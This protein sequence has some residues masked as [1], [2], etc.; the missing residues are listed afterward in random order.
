MLHFFKWSEGQRSISALSPLMFTHAAVQV[1]TVA[2]RAVCVSE[3]TPRHRHPPI[4]KLYLTCMRAWS[5]VCMLACT[6]VSHRA[7]D[8]MQIPCTVC[9]RGLRTQNNIRAVAAKHA[10]QRCVRGLSCS[11]EFTLHFTYVRSFE[12]TQVKRTGLH[13]WLRHRKAKMCPF[14]RHRKHIC[15]HR[16]L[17]SCARSIIFFFCL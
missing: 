11:A 2:H 3:T 13:K 16:F 1:L 8:S 12:D 14:N 17:S 6:R 10:Q 5:W 15:R 4:F 7:Y 9:K